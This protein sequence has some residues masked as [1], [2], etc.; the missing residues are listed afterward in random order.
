MRIIARHRHHNHAVALRAGALPAH[1]RDPDMIALHGIARDG[2]VAD[3]I[4]FC[5]PSEAAG[6][7]Q[8]GG[9]RIGFRIQDLVLR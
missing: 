3:S 9:I 8:P 4:P 1:Q 5:K 6:K 7:G 2:D